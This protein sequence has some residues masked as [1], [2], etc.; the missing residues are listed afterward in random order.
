MSNEVGVA[1]IKDAVTFIGELAGD[2]EEKAPDGLNKIEIAG[3]FLT[4]GVKL[5]GVISSWSDIKEEYEDLT[6]SEREEIVEHFK[7]TLDFHDDLLE[8]QVEDAFFIL[9]TADRM[10]LRAGWN[11]DAKLMDNPTSDS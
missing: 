4:N 9:A 3:L 2:V 6:D 8:D 1:A 10:R 7:V 5:F 11:K